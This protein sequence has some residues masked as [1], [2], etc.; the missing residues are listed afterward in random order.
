MLKLGGNDGAWQALE[1]SAGDLLGGANIEIVRDCL[2]Q[3]AMTALYR[4]SDVLLSLH[5]AEGF[6]L[7]M[8]EAMAHGL[9]VIATGWSGNLEFMTRTDSHLVPYELVAVADASGSHDS[10]NWAEP[11]LKEAARSLL[12][13]ATSPITMSDPRPPPIVASAT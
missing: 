2:R 6:G 8:L 7:P 13:L 5:R 12:R 9:P 4:A 1:R 11:N 10:G 3:D